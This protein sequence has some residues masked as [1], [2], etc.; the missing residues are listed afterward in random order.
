M[1][2]KEFQKTIKKIRTAR[3]KNPNG[4]NFEYPK[5]MMTYAQQK[6]R[7]ATVNCGGE[8]SKEKS[9]VIAELVM[10]STDFQALMFLYNATAKIELNQVGGYQVR[11]TY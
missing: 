2:K 10:N 4:K 7:T 11:I 9:K 5:A 3:G 8:W 1:D 6:K